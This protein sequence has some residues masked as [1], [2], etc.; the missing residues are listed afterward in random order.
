LDSSRLSALPEKKGL[1]V[2]I[3]RLK[4]KRDEI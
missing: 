1:R 2:P 3:G 4:A